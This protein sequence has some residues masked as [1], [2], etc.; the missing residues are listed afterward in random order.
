MTT[1]APCTR[2]GC[3]GTVMATGFCGT[4]HRLPPAGPGTTGPAST[5]DP[6]TTGPAS[7]RGPGT[8]GT[9]GPASTRAPGPAGPRAASAGPAPLDRDGLVLLPH[10]TAPDPGVA[11]TTTARPPTGGRRCGF[12]NCPGTIGIGYDGDPTPDHGFCPEC[13]RPYSFEPRLRPG[14]TVGGHYRVLGYLAAGGLGWVYLAEDTEVPDHL[15]VLKGLINTS[16]AVARRAAVE[17][18][19][20]LTTLHHR[21][22][23]RIITHVQHRAPGDD[24]PTGY[25]V[26]EYIAGRSLAWITRAS[27]EE[28]TAVFGR[29]FGID[30]VI[31]YG[32]KILGALEYL[33]EQGLLYCDMK[34]DN[35]I[36]YGRDIKVIDL[37]AI[38]R[39]DDRDSGLV[40][41]RD[42]APPKRERDRRGF[43][44]DT[45]LYTVG[46]TL[47]ALAT[48][49]APAS[50][51]AA[52]SFDALVRRATHPEPAARFASAA[53][54]SRQLWEVLREH[55]ALT[56]H[57][58]YPERSTRFAPTAAL[59]GS[60][61]GTVPGLRHWAGADPAGPRPLPAAA[62]DPREAARGLP[63]PIPDPGDPAAVLLGGLAAH[64]PER[65]AE[66]AGRDPALGTV[67]TALWLCR[68]YADR[69]APDEAG[70]WL[71]AARLR[72]A[73]EY[74]WR[75]SW[76][77][78]L[79]RL[80]E[81]R[82][83]AAEEEFAAVYAALPGE[84]APK[85]ALGYCAEYL[86]ADA[87]RTRDYYEAVWQRDRTQGSAAFGLVRAHLRDG[88]R[89][90][91]VAVLDAVPTTSRHHDAA[92]VAAVRVLAGRLPA[93]P[94]GAGA[95]RGPTARELREAV[96]RLAGPDGAGDDPATRDR[97]V[98]EV[99]ESALACRPPGGWGPGFPAGEVLGTE[100]DVPALSGLLSRSLR[101]LADRVRD[102]R[103][104]DDLLDR[105]YAVLPPPRLRLAAA[106][107]HGK[108]RDR[109]RARATR[110][111]AGT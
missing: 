11:A 91:A 47:Q 18:R 58:P 80:A 24:E 110:G 82:V 3:T 100:D 10:I 62:P 50:G 54:M 52:R 89:R 95:G 44:V 23:V 78:G 61:L 111:E 46:R 21:D 109:G 77:R 19:R 68:A 38:R 84:W 104:R 92:R 83:R 27:D 22:I 8:T 59:F 9:A 79:V 107:R 53:E 37:G 108:G 103:L 56:W 74:D 45:D 99:R 6:G 101:E 4:C 36:H 31:T 102:G 97:L 69:G 29:P 105:S 48:R 15:V 51:L 66:Q 20:S 28:L 49:A 26:M 34:P 71:E 41:T 43:H 60:D 98:A 55:Q 13:G 35:V 75:L 88:D 72:G 17:E 57:E 2:P 5:R 40:Y 85:L 81:Y 64:S 33:H 42:Y 1:S 16:D 94:R 30:H 96:E 76:H 65:V 70:R 90:G 39:V 73:G 86:S 67:E 7:T 87:E 93:G 106:G 32:C 25:I 14:D 12:E 63:A